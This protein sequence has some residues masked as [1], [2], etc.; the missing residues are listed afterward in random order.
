MLS[1]QN[2]TCTTWP[3]PYSSCHPSAPQLYRSSSSAAGWANAASAPAVAAAVPAGRSGNLKSEPN[4]RLCCSV[5][6]NAWYL[7]M[8]ASLTLRRAYFMASSKWAPRISGTSSTSSSSMESGFSALRFSRSMSFSMFS[9]MAYLQARWQ[10]SVISAP[11][12][13]CVYFARASRSTS[14]ANGDLRNSRLEVLVGDGHGVQHL[15]ING[16]I[17]EV[18]DIHLLSDALQSSFCAKSSQIG[19][20]KTH[21][22]PSNFIRHTNVNLA[23][24]SAEAT[25]GGINAVGAVS[26]AH[27]D[28][29]GTGLQ[30]VHERQ[31][32]RHNTPLHL[33]LCLLTLGCNGVDLIN[34]DDCGRILLGLLKGFAQV[35]FALSGKLRHDLR[36]VDEEEECAGL[37]GN[38]PCNESLARTGRAI[39][40]N[41][42]WRLD[43][44]RL[45]QVWMP[46]RQLD[47]LTDL[48]HLFPHTSNV[49][50]AD[51]IQTLLIL[52]ANGFTWIMPVS[53]GTPHWDT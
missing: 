36:S 39:Q 37:V 12:N 10:I 30:A 31:Q 53:I 19:S 4:P 45:E 11:L 17:L 26:G 41:A 5:C 38:C 52:S 33:T 23:I 22:Q 51:F 32:L 49:I 18:D 48:C 2:S 34:E 6:A 24:K 3:R 28:D 13:P 20:N 35:A 15:S 1:D 16:L 9:R 43:A 25:Q 47:K 46:E 8:S 42:L 14:G 44:N 27:D 50:I 29:M 40:Q 7:R 21:L